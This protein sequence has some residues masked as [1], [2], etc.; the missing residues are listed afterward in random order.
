MNKYL[1]AG[2]VA[3]ALISYIL[4]NKLQDANDRASRWQDNYE[5][6]S[7]IAKEVASLKM[8]LNEVKKDVSI[9]FDSVMSANNIKSK[10]VTKYINTDHYYRDT[11]SIPTI[12][13][14]KDTGVYEFSDTT[15]CIK[16]KGVVFLGKDDPKVFITDK[17]FNTNVKYIYYNQRKKYKFLF[18][19]WRL[20]GKK[21]NKLKVVTDCGETTTT[22]LDIIK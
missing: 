3:F 13:I 4:Y 7:D 20:F 5:E 1:I 12:V 22:D 11:D 2:L 18:W 14:K 21:E 8:T 10:S 6:V 17:S 9:K 15:E 16:I 19:N